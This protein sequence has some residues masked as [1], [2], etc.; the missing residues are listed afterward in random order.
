MQSRRPLGR[1]AA[2]SGQWPGVFLHRLLDAL[3][4]GV[5]PDGRA[6]SPTRPCRLHAC[7]AA[8]RTI[9]RRCWSM[10]QLYMVSDQ[11]VLTCVDATSG[12]EL[13]R[14]RLSGNFSASPTLADGKIFLVNEEGT[15]LRDRGG[16]K[17]ELARQQST[18]RAD[19]GFAGVWSTARSISAP[20]RI[21]IASKSPRTFAQR[22]D[23]LR[24][25]V[26]APRAAAPLPE[27]GTPAA[28]SAANC[29][30]IGREYKRRRRSARSLDRRD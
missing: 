11:G 8:C 24:A 29:G 28:V 15:M 17:F 12:K 20:T 1:A 16:D 3:A 22:H 21:C 14:Q 25:P 23:T 26:A 10:E 4:D 27:R 18:R 13:W 2:G 30:S 7:A 5:R 19:A 6:T 9:P